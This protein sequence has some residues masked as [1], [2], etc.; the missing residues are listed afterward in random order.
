MWSLPSLTFVRWQKDVE[1]DDLLRFDVGVMPLTEDP[2]AWGK[3]GFK[4]LQY[5]AL[6]IPP[7][8]SPVGVNKVIIEQGVN[9]FLCH[10][11]KEWES[12]LHTLLNDPNLRIKLGQKA[13][14]TVENNYSVRAN[15]QNFL[16]LFR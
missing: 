1:I 14:Q 10:S 6:A 16:N 5:M 9:G 3:C 12:T 7:V 2:W 13:R 11:P 4:A 8:I 15:T